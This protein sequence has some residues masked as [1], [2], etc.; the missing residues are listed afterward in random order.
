MFLKKV[1]FLGLGRPM[2]WHIELRISYFA[3]FYSLK[4]VSEEA[5]PFDYSAGPT[6]P[7]SST[8]IKNVPAHLLC[9]T[10]PKTLEMQPGKCSA[11]IVFASTEVGSKLPKEIQK[12]L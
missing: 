9:Q 3:Q 2:T 7:C 11:L 8:C 5:H 10:L 6:D 1:H 4:K 12:V